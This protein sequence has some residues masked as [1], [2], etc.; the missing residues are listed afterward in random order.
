MA[1]FDNF[2]NE[3]QHTLIERVKAAYGEEAYERWRTLPHRGEPASANCRGASTGTCGDT[4]TIF[5]TIEDD[6]VCDAGFATDGCGSSQISGSMAAELA[7]GKRC[8][9]L[10]D[11]TGEVVRDRLGGL[12]EEDEHCA[13]LAANALHDAVGDYYKRALRRT[14]NSRKQTLPPETP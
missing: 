10:T 12:L 9:D 1:E 8:E 2:V 3:L 13:W 7:I 4:I 14:D 5:L 6:T 11:I